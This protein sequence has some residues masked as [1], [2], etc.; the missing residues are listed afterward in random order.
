ME[1]E[2]GLPCPDCHLWG[3]V[4][5]LQGPQLGGLRRGPL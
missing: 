3:L 2:R 1:T 5:R 4:L